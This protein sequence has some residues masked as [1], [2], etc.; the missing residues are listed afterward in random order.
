MKVL[1][2]LLWI[3][4]GLLGVYLVILFYIYFNQDKM[5][6]YP[7]DDFSV[8]PEQF[9]LHY[10]NILIEIDDTTT[11][12][13]WYFPQKESHDAKAVLLC[14]GNAG[15]I[16]HR[17]ETAK[18]LHELGV[19]VFMF[20]YRGYGKS[21]GSPTEEGV[22]NDAENC[23][24]WLLQTKQFKAEDIF[25]FGR[26]LGGA[27][28]I[29]LAKRVQSGGLIVESSFT[30]SG[31]L[32]AKLF[33]FFPIKTLI[34]YS[35]NSVATISEIKVQK[36]ITHSPEDELIP[37]AMGQSLFKAAAEPKKFVDLSGGHNSRTYFDDP[38]YK[39]ALLELFFPDSVD[40]KE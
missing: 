9:D 4:V 21:T 14:H 1:K 5:V 37:Y 25:I 13:G 28:A 30:S 8:L 18:Y 20:D 19:A 34:R 6:F 24:D 16:S 23:F 7:T 2:M 17:L 3:P 35:F 29:E 40:S 31:D 12:H 39:N 26:S 11:I 36:L 33:P 15:N 22:Y 27:V 32:G 38:A 10:E